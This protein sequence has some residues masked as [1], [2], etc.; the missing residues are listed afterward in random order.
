MKES[1]TYQAIL[2]EG[3]VIATRNH[4]LRLGRQRF[5]PPDAAVRQELEAIQDL[6]RLNSLLDRFLSAAGWSD[7]LNG[8]SLG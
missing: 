7:L 3:E 4:I 1:T 2:E 6:N 5:G 8:S